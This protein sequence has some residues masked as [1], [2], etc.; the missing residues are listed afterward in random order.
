L[1]ETRLGAAT[2]KGGVFKPIASKLTANRH[3]AEAVSAP[4]QNRGAMP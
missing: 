3:I 1:I 4:M 2:R